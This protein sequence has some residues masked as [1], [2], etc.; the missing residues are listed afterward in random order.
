MKIVEPKS[1]FPGEVREIPVRKA[2]H[3]VVKTKIRHEVPKGPM[4]EPRAPAR[5]P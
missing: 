1:P 4:K 2:S 3:E 5:K